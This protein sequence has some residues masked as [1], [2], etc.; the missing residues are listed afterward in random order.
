MINQNV[1]WHRLDSKWGVL[2]SVDANIHNF[3]IQFLSHILNTN[4]AKDILK[5]WL[6]NHKASE[7]ADYI[8][9]GGAVD[10]LKCR[11]TFAGRSWQISRLG[12]HQEEV[13]QEDVP[14]FCTWDYT[15]LAIYTNWGMRGWRTALQKE[16]E[17]F[18]LTA[19][20]ICI[21]S[22]PL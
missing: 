18:W 7:F 20:W 21:S 13:Q 8:K 17:G 9:I 1:L 15:T 4:F 22:V 6:F 19:S 10:S 16:I 5:V 12:N 2:G 3:F 14:D 11:E